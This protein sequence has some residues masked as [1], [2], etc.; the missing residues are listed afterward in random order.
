MPTDREQIAEVVARLAYACDGKD[1]DGLRALFTDRVHYDA[2]RH[3]GGP[4]VD[5]TADEFTALA[6]KVLDGFD[7]THHALSNLLVDISGDE[8]HC[9]AYVVA[10]HHVATEPGVGDFCT[11]RGHCEFRLSRVGSGWRVREWIV[12]RTAPIEGSEGVYDIA[13]GRSR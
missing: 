10:Y 6:R 11:M 13:A 8:A 2:S 3:R 1:W 4:A 12:V 9:R 5:L 7:C